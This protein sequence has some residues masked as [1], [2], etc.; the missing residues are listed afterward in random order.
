MAKKSKVN[1]IED[2]LKD[3]RAKFG[4]ESIMK[5]DG[6]KAKDIE[7]SKTGSLGLDYALGVGG[8]PK[9]RIIEIFGPE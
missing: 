5:I 7:V 6:T 8:Y 9:G 1:S 2:V 4:Q 3:I